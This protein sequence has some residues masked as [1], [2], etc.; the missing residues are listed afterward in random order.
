MASECSQGAQKFNG[1]APVSWSVS[2]GWMCFNIDSNLNQYHWIIVY[3]IYLKKQIIYIYILYIYI[4]TPINIDILY[5]YIC[6]CVFYV[7][8]GCLCTMHMQDI[9]RRDSRPHRHQAVRS[10]YANVSSDISFMDFRC[11][12]DAT[13]P[14]NPNLIFILNYVKFIESS[15]WPSSTIAADL[16]VFARCPGSELRTEIQ[17]GY[18]DD[19]NIPITRVCSRWDHHNLDGFLVNLHHLS[20]GWQ[21]TTVKPWNL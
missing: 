6:M 18:R 14:C 7:L 5:A 19:R 2:S 13:N 4:H 11:L 17:I 3:I 20:V 9:Y 1:M 12:D 16:N 10:T 15:S 8:V 21:I